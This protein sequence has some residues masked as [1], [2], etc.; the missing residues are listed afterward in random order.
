MTDGRPAGRRPA[1]ISGFAFILVAT[2]VAGVASYIVTWLV[3][4]RIGLEHYAFFA[5]FWSFLYLVVGT[6]AG[7]Q[8]EIARGTR[9]VGVPGLGRGGRAR[10]FAIVAAL[11]VFVV[12][13]GT[14]PVWVSAVFPV[15]GW[16]LVW[17]LA[18]GAASYV[19][20]AVLSGSL[21]GVAAWLSLALMI[22]VDALLRLAALALVLAFTHNVVAL[23][24]AA[25]LPFP[26]ALLVL[27]L[28]IRRSIVGRTQLDV[29][30]RA[31]TWNVLR[32]AIAA[33]ATG[34]MV[35][36]FPFFLKLASG[37]QSADTIGLYVLVITLARAPLIIV[38]MSLQSYFTVTFRDNV[39]TFWKVFLRLQAAVLFGGIVLAALG[40]LVGPPIF[41]FLFPAS[42]LQPAGWLIGVLVLSSA[43]MAAL[44]ISAPAVLARSQHL[45]YSAGW[46]AGAI[47]TIVVLFL[48][49][50][51]TVRTVLALFIGP[52]VGL[53]VHGGYLVRANRRA[54]ASASS[55]AFPLNDSKDH[56]D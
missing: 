55:T 28:F 35:S 52:V 25:A 53:L 9:P 45:V 10:N 20:V 40:W 24:W 3:P 12:I 46:V 29:G 47:A 5:V 41:D 13:V 16:G 43:L 36:G 11:V 21:Y 15:Q 17:P 19:L 39:G 22:V 48:P 34:A 6:L 23:A 4:N 50:D 18:I 51:F 7:I 27:W 1:R 38:A 8:Q 14:A 44:C 2:A 37:G 54:Q 30:Y 56:H 26:G 33:A 32:T 31:L 42:R 49:V